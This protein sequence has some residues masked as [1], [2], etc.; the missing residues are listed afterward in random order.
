MNF[1]KLSLFF[2]LLAFSVQ[3]QIAPFIDFNGYFRTFYKN[4]FRQ[5][6]FQRIQS[7]E[8]GDNLV[9]YIDNKGDFKVY[10]GENVIPLTN[11]NVQYK[12]S[13]YHLAWNVGPGL[14]YLENRDKKLLTTFGRNYIVTDSLIVFEDTRFNTVNVVY[15]GTVIPIYQTTGEMSMP[16]VIGDNIIAFKDNGDLYRVFWRGKLYE[17]GVWMQPIDFNAGTDMLTF[18]DPTHR[19]FAI[20]ENGEFLDLESRYVNKYKSGRGFAVYEDVNG[21]L[22]HYA[23]GKKTALSNFSASFWDVKDDIVVWSE[24][25]MVYAFANGEKTRV[26]TYIPKD[27]QLKNGVFAFRNIMGGVSCFINGKVTEITNQMDAKYT[28][29]GNLVLVELFNKTFVVFSNGNLY[30]A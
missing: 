8:A 13:D 28:I 12:M 10:D 29:Y 2:V 16:Q 14:F 17:L 27:Y 26:S 20:F 3:S 7:F 22:W 23:K 15:N 6:E 9:A 18:N 19:T 24:N 1:M 21:N 30:E 25:S 5:L 11:M 4:N